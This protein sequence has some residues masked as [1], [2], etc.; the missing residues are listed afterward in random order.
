MLPVR[1]KG[2]AILAYV[3]LEG[4]TPRES[5]AD[6]LWGRRNALRN[7]RVE[8]HRLRSAF[9][10][11]GVDPLRKAVDPLS[12]TRAID[13]SEKPSAR[14][15]LVGLDD[16]SPE[17][18]SWLEHR[19]Q[20]AEQN[21]GA[22]ARTALL[23]DL[24]D[25][26]RAPFVIVLQGLPGAGRRT[27]A[28]A[29]A[30]R[31]RLPYVEDLQQQRPA[32]YYVAPEEHTLE[33][34]PERICRDRASVWVI[35]RSSYGEDSRL[36]LHVRAGVPA[37]RLRF[38]TLAPLSWLE[39]KH[40]LLEDVAFQEGASLYLAAS[41]NPG[42]LAELLDLRRRGALAAP[43][44]VPQRLRAAIA[45]EARHLGKAA[46]QA[47]ERLAVHA[48]AFTPALL[49]V[50]DATA[51]IDQLERSGWIRYDGSRWRF[52]DP[53]AAKLL[54]A[55][56][57]PG[58]RLRL[59][60]AIIGHLRVESAA[61]GGAPG[62][63]KVVSSR[64]RG[65]ADAPSGDASALHAPLGP[66]VRRVQPGP[67]I[68]SEPPVTDADDICIDGAVVAW[69]RLA[70]ERRGDGVAWPLPAEARVVRLT[71]QVHDAIDAT[72]GPGA[73][74][75][76]LRLRVHGA[77]AHAV[78][79]GLV[80]APRVEAD[81]EVWLPATR[82]FDHWILLPTGASGVHLTSDLSDAVIEV[83]VSAYE[84]DVS[85]TRNGQAVDAWDVSL[86]ADRDA[87]T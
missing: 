85:T 31:L 6:V 13:V 51:S 25:R 4:P 75:R 29:L 83:T 60:Q 49:G 23:D 20:L 18:Q 41:G 8:L 62:H 1:R 34:L 9:A 3:A 32:L 81:G 73:P 26:V 72:S 37:E 70:P 24:E 79:L 61:A 42:Y 55:G 11:T 14:G 64:Q 40:S 65:S 48:G 33:G 77:T 87:L 80:E 19:R 43:L 5:I 86:S 46:R 52:R 59:Q 47:L 21:G 82:P 54:S 22:P 38:V 15:F 2:L 35:G 74:R 68:L 30:K 78:S 84:V 27:L 17:Y 28:R 56:L 7:L 39:A 12:L 66:V 63:S 67:E 45:L 16:I 58:H 53:L 69:A 10:P 50:L 71:G 57:E 76:A 36:L 44:P